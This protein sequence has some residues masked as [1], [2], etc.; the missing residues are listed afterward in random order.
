MLRTIIIPLDGSVFS[1]RA[2]P[3]GKELACAFGARLILVC[4]AG[5][6]TAPEW[7]FTDEDRRAIAEQYADVR[8]EDHVIST[9]IRMVEHAQGQV[10]AVAEAERY[11][12]RVAVRI[13]E[14]GIPVEIAIPYG[15]AAEGILTEIEIHTADLVIMSTHGRSGVSQLIGGSVTLAVLARSTVP[16]LLVPPQG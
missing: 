7:N 16:V 15:S 14:P 3:L 2:L 8:E 12:Q 1:E 9:D 13:A 6:R 5:A 4:V 10:R 11:L